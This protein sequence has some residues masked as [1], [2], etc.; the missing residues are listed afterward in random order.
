MHRG[1]LEEP[2]EPDDLTGEL[3]ADQPDSDTPA[4]EQRLACSNRFRT[5]IQRQNLAIKQIAANVVV[6]NET[7]EH[8]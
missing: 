2:A 5:P 8:L 7:V 1:N 3:L 6:L 4:I